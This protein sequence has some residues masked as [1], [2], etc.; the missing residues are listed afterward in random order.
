MSS[1]VAST[2]SRR[3][4][5]V[6]G[7][8]YRFVFS[9]PSHHGILCG[10]AR[11]SVDD[12]EDILNRTAYR[13]D[14]PTACQ[15]FGDHIEICEMS[16]YVYAHDGIA[17]RIECD[18]RALLFLKE[19]LGYVARSIMLPTALGKRSESSRALKR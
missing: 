5:A 16:R 17:D 4:S 9:D 3:I 7:E 14:P 19:R 6:W 18:L 13:V 10:V 15:V 2:P 12:S 8:R 11:P 1:I